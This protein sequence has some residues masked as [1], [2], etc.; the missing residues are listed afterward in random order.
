MIRG[1]HRDDDVRRKVDA[2]GEGHSSAVEG[3]EVERKKSLLRAR[4][5]CEHTAEGFCGASHF[6]AVSKASQEYQVTLDGSI[7][8]IV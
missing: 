4:A 3:G 1:R 5:E 8:P 2:T 7:V 6:S